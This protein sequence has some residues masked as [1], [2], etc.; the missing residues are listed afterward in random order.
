MKYKYNYLTLYTHKDNT[1]TK[2]YTHPKCKPHPKF[3]LHPKYKPHQK[4]KLH[5]KYRFHGPTYK[6]YSKH[7]YF[8][9][10]QLGNITPTTNNP[11]TATKHALTK[12]Q[13]INK[14]KPKTPKPHPNLKTHLKLCLKLELIRTK[15]YN[16]QNKIDSPK[17]NNKNHENHKQTQTTK[18]IK[19]NNH[20][21]KNKTSL[22]TNDQ[23]NK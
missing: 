11:L 17:Q 7:T 15:Q 9:S 1:Q 21:N 12:N 16:K 8:L 2:Y 19:N 5:Q 10:K 14:T 22:Q 13:K 6:A 4:Y 18:I 3:I 20:N 23:I